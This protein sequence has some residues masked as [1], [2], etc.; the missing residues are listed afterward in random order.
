MINTREGVDSKAVCQGEDGAIVNGHRLVAFRVFSDWKEMA[1]RGEYSAFYLK[2]RY[3]VTRVSGIYEGV[4]ELA[5]LEQYAGDQARDSRANLNRLV[6][7]CGSERLDFIHERPQFDA[8]GHDLCRAAPA[9]CR[10]AAR[11]V[12]SWAST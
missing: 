11:S 3:G 7:P 10:A 4:Y 2:A 1:A 8:L 6:C 9:A 5:F 12:S